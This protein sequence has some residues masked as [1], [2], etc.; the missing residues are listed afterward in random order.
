MN[1]ISTSVSL[2][3][4]LR[5]PDDWFTIQNEIGIQRYILK[6]YGYRNSLPINSGNLNSIYIGTTLSRNS[7]DQPIYPRTGSNYTLRVQLTPPYSLFNGKDYKSPTMTDGDRYKWVEYHKWTFKA[8]TYQ[9]IVG[10]MV[11]MTR[12]NF[13]ILGRYN[14]D[15]GY[16]PFEKFNMGGSGMMMYNYTNEEIVAMRGYADGSI[17]PFEDKRV[18]NETT[19][20][21]VNQSIKQGNIYDKFTAELRYPVTLKESATIF[22]LVFAEA[23]NCWSD[24]KK[25]NPFELKRSVGF[26]VRVFLPMFGLL[27]FDMG[28]GFDELVKDNRWQPH[29]TMGQQF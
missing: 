6:D 22:G 19:N 8:E 21:Y 3:R 7:L 15:L 9:S 23:G 24:S 25:F 13:G 1:T 2:G 27:G 11:L 5:W 17:T 10:D 4:R 14:N 28:Y 16:S 12:A 18:L 26:G 29:F 20:Q